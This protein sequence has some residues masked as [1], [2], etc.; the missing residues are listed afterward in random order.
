[1]KLITIAILVLLSS[2]VNGQD[3]IGIKK[4]QQY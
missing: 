3:T 1:M 2:L 4:Q